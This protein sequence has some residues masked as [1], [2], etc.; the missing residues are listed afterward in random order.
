MP[1]PSSAILILLL[2]ATLIPNLSGAQDEEKLDRRPVDCISVPSIDD[3]EVVDDRTV[4]FFMRG[5]KVYRNYLP[6]TCPGLERQDSFSYRTTSSRLCAMD[7]IT[8]LEREPSPGVS[9]FTCA[10]GEF[11]PISPEEVEEISLGP[12]TF[13]RSAIEVEVVKLPNDAPKAADEHPETDA[14]DESSDQ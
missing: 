12:A 2:A 10:L 13:G 9:G 14:S 6:K 8:V 1:P 7:T 4:L 3:T 11:R 5:D